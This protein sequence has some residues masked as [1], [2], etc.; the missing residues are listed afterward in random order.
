MGKF[1]WKKYLIVFLITALI[2]S[3]A[4]YLSNLASEKRLDEIKSIED[5]IAIDILSSETQ[6]NLLAESSCEDLNNPGLSADLNSLAEK[7]SFEE[8]KLGSDNQ[9]VI[10]LKRYYSVLEIK[11]YLLV[12]KISEKCHVK[13]LTVLYFYSNAGDCSE[14][15]R[16]GYILTYL[17]DEYPELRVYSFD[18]N[19][20]LSTLKTLLSVFKLERKLPAVVVNSTPYYGFKSI[21]E[22]EKIMPELKTL[23]NQAASSSTTTST[24][25]K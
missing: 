10:G 12:K 4:I 11:D 5:K 23:K 1:D 8:D 19:L 16:M 9:E 20:D 3:T 25:S 17:R 14:C 18:Y 7:L 2:F 13:P 21:E 24:K 22:F 15:E 6:F